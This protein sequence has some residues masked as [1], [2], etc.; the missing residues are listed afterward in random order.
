MSLTEKG[1]D[2]WQEVLRKVPVFAYI[3]MLKHRGISDE[4][5]DELKNCNELAW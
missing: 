5:Y 2:E 4:G 3:N 1:V